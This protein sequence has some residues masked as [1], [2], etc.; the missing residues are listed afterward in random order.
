MNYIATTVQETMRGYFVLLAHLR[1]KNS[2][3]SGKNHL[4]SRIGGCA[5]LEEKASCRKHTDN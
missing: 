4:F 5:Y 2:S 1:R 3:L